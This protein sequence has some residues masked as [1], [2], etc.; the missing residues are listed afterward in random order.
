MQLKCIIAT[1]TINSVDML[2]ANIRQ[3]VHLAK[4]LGVLF[5][6]C[7]IELCFPL[8]DIR[9]LRLCWEIY[10]FI[11]LCKTAFQNNIARNITCKLNWKWP[12][13]NLSDSHWI[14]MSRILIAFD[15]CIQM[16]F[17]FIWFAVYAL[18]IYISTYYLLAYL[19]LYNNKSAVSPVPS[20]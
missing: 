18:F 11:Q 9:S 6:A 15:D 16:A 2:A 3:V 14:A 12:A 17:L 20:Y 1:F 13:E 8:I 5:Y 4:M 10:C 7:G 19:G